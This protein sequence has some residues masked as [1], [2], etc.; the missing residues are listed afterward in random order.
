MGNVF[1][2]YDGIVRGSP[3]RRKFG[4]SRNNYLGDVRFH[5]IRNDFRNNLVASVTK[6]Y[7][8]KI[9]K[10]GGILAFGNKATQSFI[11]LGIYFTMPKG[12]LAEFNNFPLDL[13]P[14]FLV[15]RGWRPSRSGTIVGL[16]ALMA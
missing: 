6:S 9:L 13:L 1:I 15:K 14:V 3:S 5:S 10:H 4:L 16:K 8:P 2:D 11:H 7:G 12:I